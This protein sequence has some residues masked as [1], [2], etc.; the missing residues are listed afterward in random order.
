VRTLLES[1]PADSP[2]RT[3][4]ELVESSLHAAQAGTLPGGA[5]N[6]AMEVMEQALYASALRLAAGNQSQVAEWLG[7]SRVT[8][9]EKLDRYD[10]LPKRSKK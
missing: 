4:A 6:A 2:A 8:V 3:I 1:P 7:V 10:L 9:R 5:L